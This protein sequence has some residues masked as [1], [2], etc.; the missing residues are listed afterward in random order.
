MNRQEA[1][2]RVRELH[3]VLRHHNY[4]YYVKDSP[5]VADSEYDR[6]FAELKQLEEQF[7][8]LAVP[9]SPTQR[10]GGFALD[11]FEKVE[12]AGAMLS[13]DSDQAENALRRFDERLR[14][15]FGDGEV[16][17]VLEPKLDGAS[18]ELVYEKG[19]LTRASTRGD[20]LV[21]EGITEGDGPEFDDDRFVGVVIIFGTAAGTAQG[22][23]DTQRQ[24]QAQAPQ[25]RDGRV[26]S[27]HAISAAT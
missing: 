13:L 17:Y 19:S 18:V 23:A 5:D 12:H 7:P 14:K 4:L 26:R 1:E 2:K 25:G 9:D 15:E 27:I 22:Q 6:L 8:E 21:G 24:G 3:A 16:A 10:V 20:G 11:Q